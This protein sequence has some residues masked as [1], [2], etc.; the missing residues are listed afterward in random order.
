MFFY[1]VAEFSSLLLCYDMSWLK[2]GTLKSVN[3]KQEIIFSIMRLAKINFFF[4]FVF[5]P[6]LAPLLQYVEVLWLGV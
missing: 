1:Q 5:L 6:F 3:M 2:N 4:F